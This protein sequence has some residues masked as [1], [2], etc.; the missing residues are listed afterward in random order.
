VRTKQENNANLRIGI[1][2]LIEAK[3]DELGIDIGS[4]NDEVIKANVL[5][6]VLEKDMLKDTLQNSSTSDIAKDL[7][8]WATK[9][10]FWK[11]IQT[12]V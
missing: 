1:K 12:Q 8:K 9:Q 10:L 11:G 7:G 4:I 5:K 3:G 6:R 2:E